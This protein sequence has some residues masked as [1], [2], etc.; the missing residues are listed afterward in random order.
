MLRLIYRQL[1][2]EPARTVI[3]SLAMAAVI[4][5]ILVLDGFQE[6]LYEQLRMTVTNRG[7]DL[8]LTQAGMSNLIAVRSIIPQLTRLD[9]ES[10]E[11]VKS[12]HPLTS[13]STIYRKNGRKNPVYIFVYDDMGGPLSLVKG[14]YIDEPREIVIDRSLAKIY[15]LSIGDPFVI[16]DFIFRIAG[17]SENT[18]AFFTPFAYINYDDLIDFYLESDIA[19][20]ITTF[21][22]L[23]YLL[24]E[25][26]EDT[27][28]QKTAQAIEY[29]V[30]EVDVFTPASL[31]E[32]DIQLGRDLFGPILNLLLSISYIIG[33]LAVGIVMFTI[34]HARKR[35]LAVIKAVGF[36]IQRIAALVT[37]ETAIMVFLA[38]PIGIAIA[39]ITAVII[40]WIAPVYLVLP[41]EPS[42]LIRTIFA[43]IVI[44]LVGSLIAVYLVAKVEPHIAFRS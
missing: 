16:N 43:C 38:F 5:L 14:G 28:Q 27:D 11:G 40:Q 36:S 21:P 9:V 42:T 1:V 30:P 10:V 25:L 18:A 19:A 23:S 26:Q 37:L 22:L 8:I 31:A 3:T 32:N 4:G 13:I 39:Q 7:A 41:T 15:N 20:D 17:I 33:L 2:Y 34:V 44:S 29:A 6:G 24:V 12:A 35:S